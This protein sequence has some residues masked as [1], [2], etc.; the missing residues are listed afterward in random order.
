MPTVVCK[1]C[2][3]K[4]SDAYSYCTQCNTP[5]PKSNRHYQSKQPQASFSYPQSEEDSHTAKTHGEEG[6]LARW[7]DGDSVKPL[8]MPR[9]FLK[10]LILSLVISIALESLLLRYGIVSSEY[11]SLTATVVYFPTQ[12][13]LLASYKLITGKEVTSGD[14]KYSLTGLA[15]LAILVIVFALL[16][17]AALGGTG[18][19]L[20]AFVGISL[21]IVISHF[22]K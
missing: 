10:A 18:A 19:S 12:F 20:G 5:I 6:L 15:L 8:V 11:A 2:R 3:A 14:R 1:K 17:F 21:Y 4:V 22:R 13:F 9:A 7:N 16:G